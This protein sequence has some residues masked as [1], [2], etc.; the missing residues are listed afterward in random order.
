MGVSAQQHTEENN[1]AEPIYGIDLVRAA[2][3]TAE[4]AYKLAIHA[5]NEAQQAE[6][7]YRDAQATYEREAQA[8]YVV[9][10]GAYRMAQREDLSSR[11]A[12][13]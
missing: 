1:M 9:E 12:M 13:R 5:S 6:N 8:A 2:E 11:F 4:R 7:R 10:A 3:Q